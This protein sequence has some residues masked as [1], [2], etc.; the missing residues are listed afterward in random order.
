MKVIY[1]GHSALLLET[2]SHTLIIDPFLSGNDLA[3]VKPEEVKPDFI[4]LTHGHE[5]HVGDTEAIARANGSTIIANFEIASYFGEKGLTTHGMYIGG[6]CT[7]PFGRVKMTIAHHGSSLGTPEGRVPMGNPAGLLITAGGKTVYHA[8]DTG[9]FLDMQLIG[10]LDAIDLAVLPI[11]DNFTMGPEDA[12]K[13]LEFLRPKA[14]LPV[15]YNTWPPIAA[16]GDAFCRE[17]EK[18]G[19]KGHA[20]KPGEALEII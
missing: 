11:G 6:Q 14:V 8:G 16:D 5:D 4:L 3:P 20:L 12:L 18:Q 1:L 10:Q 2:G 7:F 13:A 9:L 15:H 17:A 19:I